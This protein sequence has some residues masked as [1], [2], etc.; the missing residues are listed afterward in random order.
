MRRGLPALAAL[1]ILV[2]TSQGGHCPCTCAI[3][4]DA[5]GVPHLFVPG[6]GADAV[7][8]AAYATGYV[9]AEDRLFQMDL[10]RRAARG[11]LAEL[12]AVGAPFLAMDLDARRDASTEA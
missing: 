3:V 2:A 12:P 6:V 8:A 5:Y 9:Q 7:V 1:L 4:R 10:F 11:R